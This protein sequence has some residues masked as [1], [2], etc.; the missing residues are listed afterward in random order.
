M[1]WLTEQQI[2]ALDAA[3]L[4]A[5][6]ATLQ[7]PLAAARTEIAA[8]TEF[9]STEFAHLPIDP[10]KAV[11]AIQVCQKIANVRDNFAEPVR[12]LSHAVGSR[13]LS[14]FPEKIGNPSDYGFLTNTL[15]GL[16][17]MTA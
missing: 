10:A 17:A 11:A 5:Y 9:D 7:T 14:R 4:K 13:L 12:D 6:A 2:L 1:A 8:L 15:I 16:Q 3:A